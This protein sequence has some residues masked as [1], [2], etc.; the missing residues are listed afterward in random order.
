MVKD[1]L[2]GTQYVSSLALDLGVRMV[3]VVGRGHKTCGPVSSGFG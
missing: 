3:E 2:W 1:A